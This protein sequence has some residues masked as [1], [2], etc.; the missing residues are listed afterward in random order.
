MDNLQ[1]DEGTAS[2][3]AA[4]DEVTSGV[5]V[6][7]VKIIDGTPASTNAAIVDSSGNLQVETTNPS[8]AGTAGTPN[9]GVL[10]VQGITSG[11]TL[12]VTEASAAAIKTAAELID[13]AVYV[14]DA[15]WT[16]STSKHLLVGGLYQST[17]QSIT[18]G[19]V[20]PFQVDA[21]GRQIAKLAANSGVDIGDVDV[22]SLPAL[23][24][25]KGIQWSHVSNFYTTAQTSADIV[26]AS[27][28]MVFYIGRITVTS[29]FNT[30]QAG[31][32]TVQIY[33]GTGAVGDTVKHV[34]RG[35]FIT[36]PG[37]GLE[38]YP[39]AVIGNGAAPFIISAASDA[40]K[41]TTTTSGTH[42]GIAVSIDYIRV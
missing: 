13:D 8:I 28:A 11:T 1:I 40:L 37:A 25:A 42:C 30:S 20:G 32:T 15:D 18:D 14:D 36:V 10:S 21:N 9:S 17:P 19:D 31:R 3:Y 39:G 26:A 4:T 27:G 6:P 12:A 41:I 38:S 33:F 22:L 29:N 35:T 2:K 16:D 34:F 7:K 5:H 23:T 24:V